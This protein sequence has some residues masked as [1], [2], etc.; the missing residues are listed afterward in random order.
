[1]L[2]KLAT[3]NW[4]H[5]SC[6]SVL[7]HDHPYLNSQRGFSVHSLW[8]AFCCLCY[9]GEHEYAPS[10]EWDDIRWYL[11]RPTED[12]SHD[13]NPLIYNKSWCLHSPSQAVMLPQ[14]MCAT[15]RVHYKSSPVVQTELYQPTQGQSC[16]PTA[17]IT[18]RMISGLCN[19]SNTF[20]SEIMLAGREDLAEGWKTALC[21]P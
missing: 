5:F 1:M 19:V 11:L 10:R 21:C 7:L 14:C 9:S 3:Q 12:P 15:A 18:P 8:K 4:N 6:C 13:P 20:K 2:Y 17:V 16:P